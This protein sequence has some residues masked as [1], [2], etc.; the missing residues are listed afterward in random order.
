[1]IRLSEREKEAAAKYYIN[2][3]FGTAVRVFEVTYFFKNKD[4]GK[5]R[6]AETRGWVWAKTKAEAEEWMMRSYRKSNVDD[7]YLEE[8]S[9][10]LQAVELVGEPNPANI[11]AMAE[12]R[13]YEFKR[14]KPGIL[15]DKW[16]Y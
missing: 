6:I 2:S 14:D 1:M 4:T 13:P 10:S 7:R 8:A 5:Y 11:K 15:T 3:F 12:G 16:G 9:V